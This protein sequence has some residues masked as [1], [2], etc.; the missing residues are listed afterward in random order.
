MTQQDPLAACAAETRVNDIAGFDGCC[1]W[2]GL[3]AVVVAELA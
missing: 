1:T 3:V 2:P